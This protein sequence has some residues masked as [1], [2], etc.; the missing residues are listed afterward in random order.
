MSDEDEQT[1]KEMAR[2]VRSRLLYNCAFIYV[3]MANPGLVLAENASIKELVTGVKEASV[4]IC[5]HGEC[6]LPATNVDEV[7]QRLDDL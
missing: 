2:I 1:C 7:K 3:N 5:R 6:L 4:L